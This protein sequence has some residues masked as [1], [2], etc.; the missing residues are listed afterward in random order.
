MRKSLAITGLCLLALP[1]LAQDPA[2]LQP[3]QSL[4][5]ARDYDIAHM[6]AHPGQTITRM[7]LS[8]SREP[9]IE[10]LIFIIGV[11]QRGTTEDWTNSGGCRLGADGRLD[12]YIECDGGGFH[13]KVEKT[14]SLLLQNDRQGFA[15]L[16]CSEGEELAVEP[17]TAWIAPTEEHK[18]FRL[19]PAADTA[20]PDLS[21]GAAE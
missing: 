16:S 1:A 9:E 2:A 7:S 5:W 13:L 14:G 15:I 6:K 8:I 20:C 11:R 3:G 4:C 12:C 17:D 18:A 21:I 10:D 19:Q